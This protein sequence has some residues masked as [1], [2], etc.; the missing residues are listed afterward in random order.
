M[1][2]PRHLTGWG[3][4]GGSVADVVTPAGLEELRSV[5]AGGGHHDRGAI[6]RGL[7]RS[8]GDPAQNGGGSVVDLTAWDAVLDLDVVGADGTGPSVTVQAGCSLDRLLRRLLP[9][10]LWLPVVPGTRQVTVGGA[11]AADVHGKNHHV[12]G[13]FGRHVHSLDLLLTSGDVLTLTPDGPDA[14]LFWGTVGGMGLTGVVLQATIGLKRVETSRFLVDTLRLPDLA[15]LLRELETGDAHHDYSVAWFDA[16]STGRHLGRSVLTQGNSARLA[17]LDDDAARDPLELR[18]PQLPR[19]PFVPPTSL[20]NRASIRA[21]SALWYAK[22][23]RDRRGEVQDVPQFF[24]PLDAA[25]D[26]NVLYGPR[27]FCQYQFVVPFGE[28]AAFTEAVSRIASSRHSSFLNVLKRFGAGTPGPLSFPQEGW[29]LAVDLPV[30]P[31]LDVLL[32]DL[33]ALVLSAGGRIYLAKDS[34]ADAAT[35][36]AM[37]PR[38]DELRSLRD[39][40]DPGRRLS[41]DMSRRLDL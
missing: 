22:S 10:G 20:V 27:G 30:T 24:H 4:A 29:T 5:L 38:L 3:R 12:D 14:E 31:G 21:F 36:A 41:S 40:V 1:T 32:R 26:W 28:E 15:S 19:V 25:A 16:S 6:V 23:P 39:R 13:S 18:A 35:I 11:I 17:D 8:Y 9:H 37:Y 33:D 2:R 7:G 34:R